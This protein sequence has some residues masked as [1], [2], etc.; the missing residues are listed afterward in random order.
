MFRAEAGGCRGTDG[1]WGVCFG[2]LALLLSALSSYL[3]P[4]HAFSLCV[5]DQSD[6]HGIIAKG[7]RIMVFRVGDERMW[8]SG[9]RPSHDH[10]GNRSFRQ[11]HIWVTILNIYFLILIL[12]ICMLYIFNS[13]IVNTFNFLR[14]FNIVL[15]WTCLVFH[16]KRPNYLV[17]WCFM[18]LNISQTYESW[19]V[20]QTL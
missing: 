6:S 11:N 15:N 19:T 13:C 8:R 1:V 7:S 5:S 20:P 12:F 2:L 10:H 16:N 3:H 17:L 4:P 9:P 18:F 14:L